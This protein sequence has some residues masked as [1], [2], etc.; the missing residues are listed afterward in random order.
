MSRKNQT[1]EAWE[2]LFEKYDILNSVEKDGIFRC[3]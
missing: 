2:K 3:V 1:D